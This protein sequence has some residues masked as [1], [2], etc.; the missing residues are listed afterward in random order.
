MIAAEV[1]ADEGVDTLG[2]WLSHYLVE[3]LQEA[4]KDPSKKM[5]CADLILKLWQHR[6]SYRRH[7]RPLEKYQS[8]LDTIDRLDLKN[9]P[10]YF[11]FADNKQ[12]DDG[13][14][15]WLKLALEVDRTARALISFCLAQA[16]KESG[17]SGDQW[18]EAAKALEPDPQIIVLRRL[19]EI[20]E[21]YSSNE[22]EKENSTSK[23]FKSQIDAFVKIVKHVRR[24]INT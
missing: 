14:S 23:E 10:F 18:M 2:R 19:S 7:P 11:A 6:A 4:D 21:K 20:G 22:T 8:I 5:E 3:L 12:S 17:L 15:P 1:G 13:I 9:P 24:T 16:V